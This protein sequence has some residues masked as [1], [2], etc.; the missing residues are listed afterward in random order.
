MAVTTAPVRPSEPGRRP[1]RGRR[2]G[3]DRALPYLLLLPAAV[4]LGLI[5]IYPI[6]AGVHASLTT[7][8]YGRPVAGAGLKNYTDTWH[9]PVFWQ[10]MGTTLKFVV[11]AVIVETVLGLALAVLVA[12]QVRGARFI[13]MSILAPMTVAPVVVGVIWR[14]I[15]ESETGFVN[16]LF[17][18]LGLGAPN[19]LSHQGSAFFGLVLVDVW[20]WTPLLFLIC[21]AGLQSIPQEPLEAAAVDGAGPVRLFFNHTLPLLLPV[22]AVG[23]VLRLIDAVGTFDQIFVLTRGGPGTATQL[24]SIYAYNTAF[25]FT[26]YGHGAA[27][28]IALLA[29]AFLLVLV[30]LSMMRRAARRVAR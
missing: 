8:L 9:D 27:M 5:S 22:L 4:A 25:N 13:R 16:P 19:V 12:G 14:L 10:A 18:S 7:Y 29:F 20:E 30:A 26:D 23:V 15:Y 2:A 28:L 6:Y 1:D 17:T 3:L 11:I 24:I 21:L